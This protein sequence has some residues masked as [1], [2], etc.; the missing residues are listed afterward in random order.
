MTK[1]QKGGDG[2]LRL[3]AVDQGGVSGGIW[4]GDARE[5]VGIAES[6]KVP[7]RRRGTSKL[8]AVEGGFVGDTPY[9]CAGNAQV[10][11]FALG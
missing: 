10:V 8:L 1:N 4:S 6:I 11:Q 5:E 9:F 3:F 2:S 7:G